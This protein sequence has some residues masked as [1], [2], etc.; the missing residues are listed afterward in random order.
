[1]PSSADR[2]LFHQWRELSE[3]VHRLRHSEPTASNHALRQMVDA[4]P[5]GPL[6]PALLLWLADNLVLESQFDQAVGVYQDLAG[7]YAERSFGGRRWAGVAFE[8]EAACHQALG[9]AD[10]AVA[11]Y[12][13]ALAEGGEQRSE[14]LLRYRIG[15]VL[16]A[17]HRDA[18]AVDSYR[19]A[20]ATT[21]Q[22]PR[23]QA[24]TPDLARRAADRLESDR[25][26]VRP[27]PEALAAELTA[28]LATRDLDALRRLAS[29]THFSVGLVGSERSFT[30]A[31]P[32]LDLVRSHLADSTVVAN[33]S[34]LQGSGGKRYLETRG[35]RGGLLADR[36]LLLLSR[37]RDGFEWSGLGLTCLPRWTNGGPDVPDLPDEDPPNLSEGP[38]STDQTPASLWMKA[39][40]P[41]GEC[42]RAGGI[43]G[44]S[45]QLVAFTAIAA[46]FGPLAGLVYAG[47]LETASL[48]TPCGF[49]PGG[50]F[51][52]QPTTHVGIDEFAIDFSRF[53]QGVPLLLDAFGKPV[54]AVAEGVV[55]D[56][57]AG[58]GT[59]DPT[60]ENRVEI[61]HMSEAEALMAV[62]IGL[63]TGQMSPPKYT[64][65]YLHMAGPFQ[66]PVSLGMFVKQGARL[67]RVDDT[68]LSV[69]HHLHFSLHDRDLGGA[70]VRPTP[71]D[72]Q[73]LEGFWDDGSCLASTN[74]PI[75]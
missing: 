51:Y 61:G 29:P 56:V 53:V 52:G 50:L 15:E 28:A 22:E 62:I 17:A 8:Q 47:L 39:P 40:W 19:E 45:A 21:D 70:S 63:T 37:T 3:L 38:T 74:V 7:R 41:A 30:D 26:W 60:T 58:I 31:G 27:Q 12:R 16:E 24:W 46:P 13:R 65:K 36:A 66:I 1:M 43:I 64:S 44:F 42:F 59:G 20:A 54:L 57:V 67:G 34:A 35:W 18:E 73:N 9:R 72:R 5:G 11:A 23:T 55:M 75:P 4:D 2:R 32:L 69:S 33:P 14:A 25:A 48:S 49:G 68:G 71:L 6:A 10:E